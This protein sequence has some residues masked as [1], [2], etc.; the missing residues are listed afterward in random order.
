MHVKC[1]KPYHY[2]VYLD[3]SYNALNLMS[4]KILFTNANQAPL[5]TGIMSSNI[6]INHIRLEL[7][8]QIPAVGGIE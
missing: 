1:I 5:C 3:V 8:K 7:A 4:R 2:N 6:D